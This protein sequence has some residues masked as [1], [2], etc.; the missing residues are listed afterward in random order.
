MKQRFS[1]LL[2]FLL[3]L[4]L[5]VSTRAEAMGSGRVDGYAQVFLTGNSGQSEIGT[6]VAI[7]PD[8]GR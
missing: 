3:A 8:M 5:G 1:L 4:F 6:D 7:V 2:L